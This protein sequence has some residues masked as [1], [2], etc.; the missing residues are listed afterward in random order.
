MMK[1]GCIASWF[2]G[3]RMLASHVGANLAGCRWVGIPFAG[4]MA[5]IAH[6]KAS[7]IVVNDLH[8]HVINLASVNAHTELGRDLRRQLKKKIYHPDNLT[9]AQAYC[10]ENQNPE[11]PDLKAAVYYFT[12][13]WMARSG[14]A[15]TTD[16]FYGNISARWNANGGSSAV[17]YRSAVQSLRPWM[18]AMERCEFRSMDAFEFLAKCED[19]KDSGIYSDAP[20]PEA[21]DR[22][23]HPFTEAKQ[24]QLAEVLGGFTKAR[25]VVRFGEHPLIRE[26]YPES[27]WTWLPLTGRKQSNVESS[28]V[29]IINGLSKTKTN[30]KDAELE[31]S[32]F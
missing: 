6:I 27:R 4:G 2:G 15:G 11:R 10:Q 18:R 12:A 20:W 9:E 29:L 5:E 13:V 17:R 32:L 22:Y 19:T 24:R 21:G 7:T 28:D 8:K 30:R 25:V 3:N 31:G 16:E 26:L 14:I 23:R 1:I